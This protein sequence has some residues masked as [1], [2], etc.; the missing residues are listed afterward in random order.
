VGEDRPRREAQGGALT[1][2][3]AP[4]RPDG[5][6]WRN[7]YGRRHGKKLR[8]GQRALI[9][10]RL[11]ALAPAG[12]APASNPERRPIDPAAIVP[13]ARD[14]WVEIGFGG[15]EH[16][17][18]TAAARPDIGFV[19]C[20]PFVNGVAALLSRIASAGVGNVRI[21]PGDARDLFDVLPDGSL[22]RIYLLFPDPW[23]KRRH[24][25]RRFVSGPNVADMAR[26]LRPGGELRLATD[27]E[28]YAREAAET[29]AAAPAFAEPGPP[30]AWGAPWPG[31][32]GT[33]YEAKALAAGRRPLFL[34]FARR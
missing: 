24:A 3:A 18:A 15:G 21:H 31:W 19:G 16:L 22:G 9:D 34:V 17:V 27:V 7:F 10:D 6:P 2:P 8:P 30:E 5:A 26:L 25:G 1:E 11:A 33:R 20:E 13:G 32:P 14:L 12:V 29:L 4:R 23:P 28:A